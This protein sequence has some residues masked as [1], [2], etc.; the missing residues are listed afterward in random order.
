MATDGLCHSGM[1]T[2]ITFNFSNIT[3]PEEIIFG[4]A[5]NTTDYG[6]SPTGVQGPYDSL[7]FALAESAPTVGSNPQPD[8]AYLNGTNP[9]DYGGDA[10]NLGTFGQGTGWS[11]YSAA[12]EFSTTPEPSSLLLLGT[13][14]VL[15]DLGSAA[16]IRAIFPVLNRN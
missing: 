4:L 2:A 6:A 10:G 1:L 11:P 14:V 15:C 7:N 12:I 3:L 9:G 8:T 13:G 16:Q 5:F